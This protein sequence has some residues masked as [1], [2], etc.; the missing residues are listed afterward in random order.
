LDPFQI[1]KPI[2][3]DNGAG[4]DHGR[5]ALTRMKI[6]LGLH[7]RKIAARRQE[8]CVPRVVP[9]CFSA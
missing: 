8:S 2:D 1:N 4:A 5:G 6:W 7:L 9:S 3:L